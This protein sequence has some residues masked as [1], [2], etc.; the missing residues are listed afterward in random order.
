MTLIRYTALSLGNYLAGTTPAEKKS[1]APAKETIKAPGDSV[2]IQQ[3]PVPT[4]PGPGAGGG[5]DGDDVPSDDDGPG[6]GGGY[7]RD[8]IP[9][10]DDGPGKGPKGPGPAESDGPGAG[11]GYASIS[12]ILQRY[13][14]GPI[15]EFWTQPLT[16][17]NLTAN[18]NAA[19]SADKLNSTSNDFISWLQT[20]PQNSYTWT[21][22]G[23]AAP[24]A[25]KAPASPAK[26]TE[27]HQ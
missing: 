11:G 4:T 10:D 24:V 17:F 2:D 18:T 27:G 3:E 1:P 13:E 20:A 7:D 25:P 19:P 16:V 5:Y 8:A 15:A 22:D 26:K 12:G 21:Q 14:V 9:A 6:A 23:L